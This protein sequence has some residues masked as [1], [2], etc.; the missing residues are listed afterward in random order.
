MV[1]G[2]PN[3]CTQNRQKG[4]VAQ[5]AVEVEASGMASGHLVAKSTWMC[6]NRRCGTAMMSGCRETMA[7]YFPSPDSYGAGTKFLITKFLTHKVPNNKIPNH[8]IPK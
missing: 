6:E 4:A 1:E 3:R 2:K 7:V 8:R 5:S